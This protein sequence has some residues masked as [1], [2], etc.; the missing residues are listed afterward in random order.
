M[1]DIDDRFVD[2]DFETDPRYVFGDRGAACFDADTLFYEDVVPVIPRDQ[3]PA[4]AEKCDAEKNGLEWLV[5]RIY[6][7]SNE[8]SCV[9]N[10][11]SQAH[12]IIQAKENGRENVIHLSAISLYK[13]IGRSP[14]SGA[15]VSDGLEE[16]TDRG[17]LPL[18]TPENR[19]KFGDKVMPNT[20]FYK[21]YPSD[22]EATAALLKGVERFVIRSFDGLVTAGFNGHPAVVGR[23]GHSICYNRATYKSGRLLMPYPNSWRIDWGSPFG[24]MTGGFGFDSESQIKQSAGWAFALRSTN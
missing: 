20:G 14:N 5:T 9:A 6:D 19:A 13:R 17:I 2:V 8:G 1:Q 12:E 24:A 16:M 11:C 23:Q 22:W 4:L 18:D 3:W 21:A 7:Q 15:M 10:A